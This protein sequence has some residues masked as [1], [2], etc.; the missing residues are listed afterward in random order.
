MVATIARVVK[1]IRAR[2]VLRLGERRCG[3]AEV[4]CV[5]V[6]KCTAKL[7]RSTARESDA[8]TGHRHHRG[9][10]HAEQINAPLAQRV[11]KRSAR[12]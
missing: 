12:R 8:H 10:F 3:V 2:E 7:P 6:K 4:W 11:R 5:V 1:V 9:G